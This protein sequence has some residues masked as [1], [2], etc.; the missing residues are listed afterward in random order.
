MVCTEIFSDMQNNFCKQL[1]LTHVLQK[2]EL[3]TKIYLYWCQIKLEFF[4]QIFRAFQNVW[5][6]AN[7]WYKIVWHYFNSVSIF[8]LVHTCA[9]WDFLQMGDLLRTHYGNCR[10]NWAYSWNIPWWKK[11]IV[12]HNFFFLLL[13]YGRKHLYSQ[14]TNPLH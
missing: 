6:L 11:T 3:L 13:S 5:T 2:E 14:N 1:V 7:V 10:S 9:K 4:F 12:W 8:F